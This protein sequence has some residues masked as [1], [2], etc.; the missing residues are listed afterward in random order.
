MIL[1]GGLIA[2]VAAA[3]L[4]GIWAA[5]LVLG[6]SMILVGI[7]MGISLDMEKVSR[8]IGHYDD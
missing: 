4:A 7:G 2:F 3:L 5:V 1:Y 6:A 8:Q